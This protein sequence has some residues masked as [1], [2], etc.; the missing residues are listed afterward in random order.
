MSLPAARKKHPQR[1]ELWGGANFVPLAANA[2]RIGPTWNG[3]FIGSSCPR[4]VHRWTQLQPYGPCSRH[5]TVG[6]VD[7]V[8]HIGQ[9]SGLEDGLSH[10]VAPDGQAIFGGT[11]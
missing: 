8:L 6:D 7:G 11:Q 3:V 2:Q 10:L 1:R 5:H 4:E 9:Q